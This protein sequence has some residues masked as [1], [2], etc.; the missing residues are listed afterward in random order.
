MEEET[1]IE[2]LAV[3]CMFDGGRLAPVAV[4]L[5]LIDAGVLDK[6]RLLDIIESLHGILAAEYV[7]HLGDIGDAELGLRS[8]RE[9]LDGFDWK[10]GRVLEELRTQESLEFLRSQMRL[11]NS[12]HRKTPPKDGTE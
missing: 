12:K 8:L 1:D 6:G 2:I 4:A 5:A 7:G 9:W 11:A 10:Q 3:Q